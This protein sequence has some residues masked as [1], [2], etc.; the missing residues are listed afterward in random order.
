MSALDVALANPLFGVALTVGAYAPAA[1]A[2]EALG[3]TPLLHPVLTATVAVALALHVLGMSYGAY[4][5]QTAP[6]HLAL[7]VVVV[8]LAVPLHRQSGCIRAAHG[9]I[10]VALPLGAATA[11]AT[12]LIVP[13]MTGAPEWLLATAASKAATT[14]VAVQVSER[15][16]GEP[17]LT[18]LLVV[19]TGIFGATFGP[20]ILARAGV[21][22]ERAVGLAMG[23]ASHVI[24]T[25]RAF[26][27]SDRAGAFATIGMILNA[28][29]FVLLAPLALGAR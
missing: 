5:A 28:L 3:R 1:A 16:G 27:I 11:V 29:L 17:G 6:L 24:G 26:A 20:A 12:A 25:A 19:A 22:D 15:L 4:F 10:A 9:P 7:G 14:P 18:A 13:I 23:V 21:T 2:H 8:L